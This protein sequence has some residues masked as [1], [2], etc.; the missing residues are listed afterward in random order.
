M[1]HHIISEH[2]LED[3]YSPLLLTLSQTLP[4][5]RIIEHHMANERILVVDFY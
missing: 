1:E 5:C 3:F 2:V 4:L